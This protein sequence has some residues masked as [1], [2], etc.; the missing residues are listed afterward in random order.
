[1]R[2]LRRFDL[3]RG[4]AARVL[5]I[6]LDDLFA[7][8]LVACLRLCCRL[9]SGLSLTASHD[10]TV[11]RL[12]RSLPQSHPHLAVCKG[13]LDV[14]GAQPN[15]IFKSGCHN[16]AVEYKLSKLVPALAAHTDHRSSRTAP[17]TV[18]SCFESSRLEL[19]EF[20]GCGRRWH[21]CGPADRFR[22]WTSRPWRRL[23]EPSLLQG[24]PQQLGTLLLLEEGRRDTAGVARAADAVRTICV[25]L[26]AGIGAGSEDPAAQ[27]GDLAALRHA[28][29]EMHSTAALAPDRL[30]PDSGIA[31]LP[32]DA[33][34]VT[35][36]PRRPSG[37]QARLWA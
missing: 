6:D 27:R 32:D 33:R 20:L 13:D 11:H 19:A 7:R 5:I 4:P 36:S 35:R 12:V 8:R 10:P 37:P 29:R 15:P 2:V 23:A 21:D 24:K 28:R 34:A 26:N 17:D 30:E 9:R 16:R 31:H 3:G 1:M 25:G 18:A 22:R 14:A